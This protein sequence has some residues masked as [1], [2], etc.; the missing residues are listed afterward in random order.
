M[1][2]T[3]TALNTITDGGINVYALRT[4]FFFPNKSGKIILAA[5]ISLTS[6]KIIMLFFF[7]FLQEKLMLVKLSN[8]ITNKIL[9]VFR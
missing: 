4:H 5:S 7:F 3:N 8:V 9:Q 6:E 2:C 1:L